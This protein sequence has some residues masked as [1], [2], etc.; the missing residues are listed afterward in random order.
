MPVVSPSDELL[1]LRN[2]VS[3]LTRRE[4]ELAGVQSENE[5]LRTQVASARTNTATH[6]PANI[7]RKSAARNMGRA[8]PDATLETF[9][10]AIRNRDLPVFLDCFTPEAA[11]QIKQHAEAGGKSVEQFF[12]GSDGIM[13]II[14]VVERLEI[15][16][17]LQYRV[18]TAL[19]DSSTE[20]IRFRLINGEW[21]MEH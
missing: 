3:Q 21:K 12:E 11:T 18:E 8:T 15:D 5:R 20:L 10:W 9:L 6:L 13:P 19:G 17:Q 7:F 16:G 4:R 1:R 2:E 14:N